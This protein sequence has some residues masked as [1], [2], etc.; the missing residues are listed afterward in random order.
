MDVVRPAAH[1]AVLDALHRHL[2]SRVWSWA[3][4]EVMDLEQDVMLLLF[5]QDGKRLRA[6]NPELG[7]SLAGWVKVI[8]RNR[9][10]GYLRKKKNHGITNHDSLDA[11]GV[12]DLPVPEDGPARRVEEKQMLRVVLA[13]M[14]REQTEEARVL[15]HMIYVESLDVAEVCA[16]TNA[17]PNNVHVRCS[18]FLKQ[19]G[20]VTQRILDDR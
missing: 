15:F 19:A 20:E 3:R 5:E 18:R 13:E 6:W 10:L 7:I 8:A 14:H 16:R 2:P 11:E 12:G 1:V 4:H 9:T 17:T